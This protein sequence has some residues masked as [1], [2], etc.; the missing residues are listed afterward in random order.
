MYK[1]KEL[2]L[3][4]IIKGREGAHEVSISGIASHNEEFKVMINKEGEC[5]N[6]P[7]F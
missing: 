5:S 3:F 2:F 7:V 1:V 4:I 6:K